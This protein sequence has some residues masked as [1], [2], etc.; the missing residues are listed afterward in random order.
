MV[1]E[2]L[3]DVSTTAWQE[4]RRN[5]LALLS[6]RFTQDRRPFDK[7]AELAGHNDVYIGCSCPTAKNP[8][9]KHCHTT[10]ALRFMKKQYP[11]LKVLLPDEVGGA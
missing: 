1:T 8:S 2:Y 10:L 3:A 7:L 6:M 5:Y 11:E 9:V 4:F